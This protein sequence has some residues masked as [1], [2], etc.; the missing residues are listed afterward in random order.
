MIGLLG[1]TR[2][3]HVAIGAISLAAILLSMTRQGPADARPSLGGISSTTRIPWNADKNGIAEVYAAS[4]RAWVVSRGISGSGESNV[5]RLNTSSGATHHM[6]DSPKFELF[7]PTSR[8]IWGTVL[9]DETSAT[10]RRVVR[11]PLPIGRRRTTWPVPPACQRTL[12]TLSVTFGD[13]VWV[14]CETA[15]L[16]VQPGSRRTDLRKV[17]QLEAML[18]AEN[19]LWFIEGRRVH[20]AA[21]RAKGSGFILP[22]RLDIMATTTKGNKGWAIASSTTGRL[23]LLQLDFGK[24]TVRSSPLE[25]RAGLLRSLVSVEREL[26][27]ADSGT[28]SIVRFDR[29]G[30]RLGAIVLRPKHGFRYPYPFLVLSGGEKYVWAS[31]NRPPFAL[32]RVTP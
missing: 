17:R 14:D 19:G 28:A 9:R 15:V 7:A 4:S 29:F 5:W 1:M 31:V 6:P 10:S 11:V 23:V 30:R 12:G 13:S 22:A 20:A 8:S 16:T 3:S 18:P 24:R 27:A 2:R 32:Y 21:G 26:W 25:S